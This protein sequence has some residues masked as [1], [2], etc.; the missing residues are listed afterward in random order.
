MRLFANHTAA[1]PPVL[2]AE[3]AEPTHDPQQ[4]AFESLLQLTDT[5]RHHWLDAPVSAPTP[6]AAVLSLA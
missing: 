4:A 5:L 1:A 3:T 6:Q 2:G